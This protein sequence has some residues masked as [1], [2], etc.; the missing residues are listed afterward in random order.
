MVNR[1]SLFLLII[2][3][4]ISL[5][6]TFVAAQSY[7]IRPV[8]MIVGFTPG[9]TTDILARMIGQKLSDQLR[10]PLVIDNRPGAGGTIG[11]TLAAQSIPDG[12]TLWLSSTGQLAVSPS[13]YRKL[14]YDPVKDFTPIIKVAQVPN[15]LV[16]HPSLPVRSVKEL[17]AFIKSRPGQVNYASSG[18]GSASHLNL[19][20][21]KSMAGVDMVEIPYKSS[22]QAMTDLISGQVP[23][24][25]P[26]LTATLPHIR[27]GKLVALAVTSD[28]R[29]QAIPDVPTM[30][31][32]GVRGY[33]ATN[34]YCISAPAHTPQ[35]IVIHLNKELN[36][37]LGLPEL[38]KQLLDLGAMPVGGTPDDMAAYIREDLEKWG[39]LISQLG[40]RTN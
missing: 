24:N 4:S 20:L 35:T 39:K 7:P 12:Y 37:I 1:R 15:V 36:G 5:H 33:A 6:S 19:E 11:A 23:L 13:L 34:M 29:S 8:R 26:S 22:A 32:A 9:T 31:E 16:V 27:S 18:K 30:A 17:I 21:F 40:L 14:Q 28:K 25:V 2:A 10:Q 38:R 3:L